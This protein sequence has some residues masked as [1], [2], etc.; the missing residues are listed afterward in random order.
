MPLCLIKHSAIKMCREFSCT[1]VQSQTC[2]SWRWSSVHYGHIICKERAC[3]HCCTEEWVGHRT[4]LNMVL[5]WSIIQLVH[6]CYTELLQIWGLGL[7][8]SFQ[9]CCFFIICVVLNERVIELW[10][11]KEMAIVCFKQLSWVVPGRGE[12]NHE[13]I[14]Q[15]TQHVGRKSDLWPSEL[16]RSTEHLGVVNTYW[17]WCLLLAAFREQC[18]HV[19]WDSTATLPAGCT[20]HSFEVT[21]TLRS[22]RGASV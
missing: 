6:S 12:E 1:F 9:W 15:D 18:C 11:G 4:S 7:F 5:I 19:Q 10:I 16:R 3:S 13:N 8:T 20:Q 21:L 22:Y 2:V 17:V 14:I